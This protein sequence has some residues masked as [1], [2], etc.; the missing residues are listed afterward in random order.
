MR[1]PKGFTLIEMLVV[2]L[3]IVVILALLLPAYGRARAMVSRAQCGANLSQ[4]HKLMLMYSNENFNSDHFPI[5][6]V[7]TNDPDFTEA[8]GWM[9][10]EGGPL[11]NPGDSETLERVSP[12]RCLW[13]LTRAPYKASLSLFIC[14]AAAHDTPSGEDNLDVYYDFGGYGRVSYGYQLPWGQGN[15]VKPSTKLVSPRMIIAA[16]KGPYNGFKRISPSGR[17]TGSVKIED[18]DAKDEPEEII[19]PGDPRD[20]E[21]RDL[22]DI[23]DLN[24]VSVEAWQEFNSRNHPSDTGGEGQNVL[25]MAGDVQFINTPHGY[26]EDN[27]YTVH[28]IE[29]GQASDAKEWKVGQRP[30]SQGERMAPFRQT[31]TFIW[32]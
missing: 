24:R 9:R 32:P 12:S 16:D 21:R 28:K 13:M 1:R 3:I 10:T 20:N 22:D 15:R 17:S 11:L 18:V 29:G 27:I 26:Q 2:V 25:A 7:T 6:S 19:P 31:D 30:E 23:D 14:P 4:I 8:V 5:F